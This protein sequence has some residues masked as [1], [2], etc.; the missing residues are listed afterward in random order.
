MAYSE[1]ALIVVDV[2]VGNGLVGTEWVVVT[3]LAV[4]LSF[5]VAAPVNAS[6]HELFRSLSPWLERLERDKRHP[7]DEPISLGRAEILIVGMGRVGA[8]AYD[9]LKQQNENIVGIDSDPGKIES[10]LR[11]GRRVAYADAEDPSFWHLLNIDRLRAIMLALP[12]LQAKVS[13]A[14]ALRRR[15][16]R[17]LLSATHLD[18]EEREPIIEAGCDVTYNYYTEAGVGFARHTYETLLSPD[19]ALTPAKPAKVRKAL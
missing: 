15:G 8:G 7:D 3:A 2:A 4:A 1:F 17:G 19:A 12:D 5:V 10:N 9:Y 13:A 16:Y 14:R 11:E 6:A 18:P